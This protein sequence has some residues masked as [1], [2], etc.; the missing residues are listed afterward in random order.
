[1]TAGNGIF[2]HSV[3]APIIEQRRPCSELTVS[4]A[5]PAAGVCSERPLLLAESEI[6]SE[7]L[8]RPQ[9][10]RPCPA[11]RTD[12][13]GLVTH[14]DRPRTAV[15]PPSVHVSVYD[16]WAVQRNRQRSLSDY[17][18]GFHGGSNSRPD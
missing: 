6:R 3:P 16:P 11:P 1:M 14:L 8:R 2:R 18:S 17:E 4:L 12:S 10:R 5:R 15:F 13:A 7:Q 9:R